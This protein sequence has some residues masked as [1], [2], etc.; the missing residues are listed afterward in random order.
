MAVGGWVEEGKS[1]GSTRC[2]PYLIFLPLTLSLTLA[3]RG[4]YFA[5]G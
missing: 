3:L 2:C 1:Q 4:A 5:V